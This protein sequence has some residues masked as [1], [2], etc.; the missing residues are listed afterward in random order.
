MKR[1]YHSEIEGMIDFYKEL[2]IRPS[3]DLNTDGVINNVLIEFKK[4]KSVDG[5]VSKH[6]EQLKRY[7]KAY[8]SAAKNIPSISFL[9]YI[10]SGEYIKINN[11]NNLVI[12]EDKWK[13]PTEFKEKI[14]GNDKPPIKGYID[15]FSIVSYNNKFCNE[16]KNDAT[17]E[18]VKQ[19]FLN[20][21]K[22][23]IIPFNWEEQIKSE[24]DKI[25]W[26]HFNMNQLGNILLK[27]QLGAFFTPEH[28]VEKSTQYIRAA[29]KRSKEGGYKDYLIIDRCAGTGNLERL[30]NAEELSHCIL[31]TFD[32]T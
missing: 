3:Y 28:Y 9:I 13:N 26:L 8:N 11:E 24:K 5:G 25:G 22:L 6:K 17:K 2:E 7:L 16:F 23:N 19:E 1:F 18:D 20:P 29:I 21:K 14:L 31:N 32:Y 10:N 15:E 12:E 30:L 4:T 27:K